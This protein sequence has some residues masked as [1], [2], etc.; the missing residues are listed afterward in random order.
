MYAS[1]KGSGESACADSFVF[2]PVFHFQTFH[3]AVNMKS[4]YVVIPEFGTL[5]R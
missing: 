1:N 3:V 2:A 5:H 4:P